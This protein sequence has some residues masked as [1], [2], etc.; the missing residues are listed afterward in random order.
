MIKFT[1]DSFSLSNEILCHETS[2]STGSNITIHK[3]FNGT[4][5]DNNKVIL[6]EDAKLKNVKVIIRGT[7]NTVHFKKNSHFI[8][9]V[10]ITGSSMNVVIGEN[11]HINGAE[12]TCRDQDIIIGSDCLLSNKIVI[13]SSDTHKIFCNKTNKQINKATKPVIVS[14][15]V[16]IGQGVFIGKNVT[17]PYGSVVAAGSII[18]RT[19]TEESVVIGGVRGEILKRD[20]RWEK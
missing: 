5:G 2:N 6:D 7:G 4:G 10:N 3:F 8:G 9:L 16:W 15:N 19:I 17:I 11:T 12:I 20:I 14:D 1:S 13:R 18:T